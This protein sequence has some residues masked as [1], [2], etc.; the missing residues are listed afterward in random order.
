MAVWRQ[1]ALHTAVT[2]A[3]QQE[4]TLEAEPETYGGAFSGGVGR[5]IDETEP[6]PSGPRRAEPDERVFG[7]FFFARGL[8]GPQGF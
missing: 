5:G 8:S 4:T 6:A 7:A 1:H 3:E 2:E